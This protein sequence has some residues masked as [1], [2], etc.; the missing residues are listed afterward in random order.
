MEDLVM[1]DVPSTSRLAG[2]L[3]YLFEDRPELRSASVDELVSRLDHED[4]YARAR[5]AYQAESD[6]FVHDHLEEFP[7]RI[8]REMVVD[9]LKRLGDPRA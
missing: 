2:Q 9:A 3:E 6:R 1:T 5:E 7:P 8:T 4:R